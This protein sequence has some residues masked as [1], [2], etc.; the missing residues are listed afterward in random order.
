[1]GWP[2]YYTYSNARDVR[3][4]LIGRAS[5]EYRLWRNYCWDEEGSVTDTLGIITNYQG[6]WYCC[7]DGRLSAP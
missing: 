6:D 2:S 5:W 3:Y 4:P 1:M 7:V